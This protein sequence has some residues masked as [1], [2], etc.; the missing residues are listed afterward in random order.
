MVSAQNIFKNNIFTNNIF[1]N[2]AVNQSLFNQDSRRRH[3][4]RQ[5][6]VALLLGA[7]SLLIAHVTHCDAGAGK[8][9]ECPICKVS[10]RIVQPTPTVTA[11][12]FLFTF[13]ILKSHEH[14]H[15]YVSVHAERFIRPPPVV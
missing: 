12:Y 6:T 3:L 13:F 7:F 11:P 9:T 5:I 10:Q 14:V 15:A 8:S 4:F 1:K 2:S